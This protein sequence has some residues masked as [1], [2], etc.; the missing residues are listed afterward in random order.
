MDNKRHENLTAARAKQESGER[1]SG[2]EI[3]AAHGPVVQPSRE[4]LAKG[5]AAAQF[6][7][8]EVAASRHFQTPAEIRAE[9]AASEAERA[10]DLKRDADRKAGTAESPMHH[11][12]GRA[13]GR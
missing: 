8:P 11:F 9:Y 6:F 10:A 3:R 12:H 7:K 4:T 5:D 13:R 2:T 1:P